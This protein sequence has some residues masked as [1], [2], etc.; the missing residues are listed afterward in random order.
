MKTAHI[1]VPVA[2]IYRDYTFTSEVVT[3]GFLHEEVT[4]LDGHDN[5]SKVEQWDGYKGWI[6]NFYI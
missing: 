5:W 1:I 2:D 3:Q 6:N 4:I